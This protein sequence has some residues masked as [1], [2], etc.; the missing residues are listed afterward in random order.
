MTV[1]GIDVERCAVKDS[2]ITKGSGLYNGRNSSFDPQPARRPDKMTPIDSA[3]L[4]VARTLPLFN[5]SAAAIF[6]LKANINRLDKN[7]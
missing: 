5:R 1:M 3:R 6:H 2:S 7:H 4:H